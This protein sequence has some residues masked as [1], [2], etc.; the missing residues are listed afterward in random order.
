MLLIGFTPT[1]AQTA[2]APTVGDGTKTNPYQIASLENLYWLADK[3][4]NSKETFSGKYFKQT[5]NISALE[6]SDW[7]D[8]NGWQPI[9]YFKNSDDSVSFSG[10][11]D[12][13]DKKIDG[14]YINRPKKF[15]VGLFGYTKNASIANVAVTNVSITG[16]GI[17][18]G[19]VGSN[20]ESP[21]TNSYVTGVIYSDGI[22]GMIGGLVGSNSNS[23]I[24]DSYMI[25][26]INGNGATNIGGF[27]GMN[28][29]STIRNSRAAGAISG[30]SFV[31][32]FIGMNSNSTITNCCTNGVTHGNGL[33]VGGLV[34][35]NSSST[36]TNSCA[37][38]SVNGNGS[39]G[40]F[41]GSNSDGS[42]IANCYVIG[43]VNSDNGF[44]FGGLAGL[45]TDL[46]SIKNCYAVAKVTATFSFG[47]LVGENNNST[48]SAS[49]WDKTVQGTGNKIGEGKTS[50]EMKQKSTYTGWDFVRGKDGFWDIDETK[51]KNNGY[52]Y[53]E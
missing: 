43:S 22:M 45:N 5:K 33:F 44:Y 50:I 24:M 29:N 3:V 17:L 46:S 10:T 11:Y 1:F 21:I 25:G 39:T 48:V 34:G 36:I 38:V 18:G 12:G 27:I 53:L 7:F 35:M 19:L 13:A 23:T 40:G 2:V 49:F 30:D 16:G 47:G 9:G 42:T 31:G 15:Y 20:S 26:V 37:R 52:P 4:N 8:G 51:L 6:T 28:S 41:T 14:L 32:G